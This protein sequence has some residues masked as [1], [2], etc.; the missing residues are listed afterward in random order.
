MA[1]AEV[2][3]FKIILDSSF[4]LLLWVYRQRVMSVGRRVWH[5]IHVD[6]RGQLCTI[7]SLHPPLK[8]WELELKLLDLYSNLLYLH[9]HLVGPWCWFCGCRW[10]ALVWLFFYLITISCVGRLFHLKTQFISRH[11]NVIPAV[12]KSPSNQDG[13]WQLSS[14]P[15]LKDHALPFEHPNLTLQ[16]QWAVTVTVHATQLTLWY[17]QLVWGS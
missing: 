14:L 2:L 16:R 10:L 4:P 13:C 11:K 17:K 7:I 1:T 3:L 9:S 5:S 8:I 6:I 12:W 15:M